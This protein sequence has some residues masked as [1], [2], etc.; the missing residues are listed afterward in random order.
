MGAANLALL[1]MGGMG[2][3][4]VGR[5]PGQWRKR[6]SSLQEPLRVFSP[7]LSCSRKFLKRLFLNYFP[8]HLQS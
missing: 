6:S 7:I 4:G 5:S 2:W 3:D 1:T 8:R